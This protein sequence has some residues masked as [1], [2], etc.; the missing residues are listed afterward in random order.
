MPTVPGVGLGGSA[1][2]GEP[3][4]EDRVVE[5]VNAL[6][7]AKKRKQGN[8]WDVTITIWMDL[9]LRALLRRA[10]EK[11]GMSVGGYVRRA[12]VAYLCADLGVDWKETLRHVP[13]PSPAGGSLTREPQTNPRNR[14]GRLEDDGTGF[15]DWTLPVLRKEVD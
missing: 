8:K 11:R 7:A 4:W 13:Y 6:Q 10:A 9:P 2:G 15:G 14:P 3:G 12:A 1:D 5:S